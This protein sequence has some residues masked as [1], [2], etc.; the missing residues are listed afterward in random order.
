MLVKMILEINTIRIKMIKDGL[1]TNKGVEATKIP[2]EWY[3]WMHHTINDEPFSN[4]KE[5]I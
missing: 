2:P 1:Y 5:K 4:I 3:L